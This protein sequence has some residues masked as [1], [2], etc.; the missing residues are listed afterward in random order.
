MKYS[1][2]NSVSNSSNDNTIICNSACTR[3]SSNKLNDGS[4]SLE[5]NISSLVIVMFFI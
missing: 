3:N 1:S 2:N 4:C 5:T